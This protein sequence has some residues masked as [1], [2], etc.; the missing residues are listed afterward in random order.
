MKTVPSILARHML[1]FNWDVRRIPVSVR[2]AAF[3][4]QGREWCWTAFTD[5]QSFR[6]WEIETGAARVP[7]E[8]VIPMIE[9]F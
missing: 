4:L 2:P 9:V 1:S 3:G 8:S 6:W 7:D 5:S